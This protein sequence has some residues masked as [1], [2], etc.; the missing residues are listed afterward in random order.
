MTKDYSISILRQLLDDEHK[1]LS[2]FVHASHQDLVS[3]YHQDCRLLS[4]GFQ[5]KAERP[6]SGPI[7][8]LPT[9]SLDANAHII[10]ES[11]DET[12][13]GE[14]LQHMSSCFSA[15]I[16]AASLQEPPMAQ[17]DGVTTSVCLADSGDQSITTGEVSRLS[18]RQQTKEREVRILTAAEI[19]ASRRSAYRESRQ[20]G[21]TNSQDAMP[22]PYKLG[23]NVSSRNSIIRN[24]GDEDSNDG[25]TSPKQLLKSPGFECL[26]AALIFINTMTM[27]FEQQYAGIQIGYDLGYPGHN[28]QA[29][30]A[31]PSAQVA[32]DIMEV[33]FGIVFLVEVLIKLGVLKC[34]FF[35]SFWN[36]Y[37]TVIVTFW[38]IDKLS[39]VN[40][41][42][43]PLLLRLARMARLLRLLRFVKTFQVFDILHLLVK[44]FRNCVSTL[45]WSVVLLF[46]IMM[47]A[48]LI[49]TYVLS[50]EF[51][52]E[53]IE[54]EERLLLF[55]YFGTFTNAFFSMYELT[56]GNWVPISRTVIRNI[57]DWY[58]LF[59][60][61]Y[62]TIVGF[63]V[64]KVITAIFNAETLRVAQSDDAIMLMQKERLV[65]KH[66][67]RMEQLMLEGDTSQ[68]GELC[69]Q[70]FIDLIEDPRVQR[71]LSAQD[72]EVKD[73]ELAFSMLD[74]NGNGRLSPEEL[75]RG[76]ARLKGT[77][78]SMDMVT[79]LHAFHAVEV[80]T[81]GIQT[82][83]EDVLDDVDELHERL[84]GVQTVESTTSVMGKQLSPRRHMA[85]LTSSNTGDFSDTRKE[86]KVKTTLGNN[87][88]K[89]FF[90]EAEALVKS[91]RAKT[92]ES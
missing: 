76:F 13:Q 10:L 82:M 11:V 21:N 16:K 67:Q 18:S 79:V 26:F 7:T 2:E 8:P 58:V 54:Y 63:A 91:S 31:W 20:S 39:S 60:L 1:R 68:D 27:A 81:H 41:V 75:V 4:N 55:E 19:R 44:A 34:A 37:D 65:R 47:S 51:E 6:Y 30:K 57:N 90:D 66:T 83:L 77:A 43:H 85:R 40:I 29:E 28:T 86:K 61:T 17:D 45:L 52:N 84:D 22:N 73:V 25:T 42:I 89:A 56:M 46:L 70:E 36:L 49:L 35:L 87:I 80:L 88:S 38:V 48:A 33:L 24:P 78:R 23:P 32:F 5:A 14:Q 71:W 3:R 69:I 59:F 74:H 64:L 12:S 92:D 62:R 50:P 72:I 9:E 15:V 53:N